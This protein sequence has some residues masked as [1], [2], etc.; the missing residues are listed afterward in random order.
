MDQYVKVGIDNTITTITLPED[1]CAEMAKA[2]GCQYIEPFT[3]SG[4]T[5]IGPRYRGLRILA[6]EEGSLKPN[7]INPIIS[8]LFGSVIFGECLIGELRTERGIPDIHGIPGRKIERVL[9]LVNLI[10]KEVES[11]G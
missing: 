4:L 8:T 7:E 3:C 10:K 11:R 9:E 2:I 6:D 1:S 5:H